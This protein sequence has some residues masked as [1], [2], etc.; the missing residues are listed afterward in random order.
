MAR[1]K[2][3]NDSVV[4]LVGAGPGD[5]ELLTIRAFRVL[6]RAD[7]LLYDSLVEPAILELTPEHCR[8]IF[9]G[10][11]KGRHSLPQAEINELILASLDSGKCVVRLKGGDP[12]IFGR[13]GE[14]LDFL[15]SRGVRIEVVPGVTTASAASAVL[16]I[17]LTHRDIGRSVIFLTGYSGAGRNDDGFP[18]YD[19]QFLARPTLTLVIYMGLH[20][21]ARIASTLLE[22]GREPATPVAV[23]SNCTLRDQRVHATRL[24]S[25]AALAASGE[26]AFPAIVIVGQVVGLLRALPEEG[27]KARWPLPLEVVGELRGQR[28]A[29]LERFGEDDSVP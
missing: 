19:W 21:L 14:E 3:K 15:R 29:I 12:F 18:D 4:Y 24:D 27:E 9:V 11:R 1:S 23:I 20:H 8:R 10:K 5:P 28:A 26:L 17:P 7:C 22:A 13:G 6:A 16:Q 25:L 2:K